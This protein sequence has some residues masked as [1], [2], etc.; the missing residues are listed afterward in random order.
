M[1]FT[2]FNCSNLQYM[3]SG[4]LYSNTEFFHKDE[5]QFEDKNKIFIDSGFEKNIYL[6]YNNPVNH[7][8]KLLSQKHIE[9]EIIS[10]FDKAILESQRTNNYYEKKYEITEKKREIINNIVKDRNRK[11]KEKEMIE[12]KILEETL[13]RII[14]DSLKFTKENSPIFAMMPNKISSAINEIKEKKKRNSSVNMNNVN[15][16]NSFNLSLISN[17]STTQCK[18]ESNGFLKALGLDLE[19]LTPDSI[20]IDIDEAYKFIKKWKINR[21]DINEIIR[22]KVVN[23]IMNVEERRSVQKLKRLN[24]K[25]DKYVEY[26]K[27]NE[28]INRQITEKSLDDYDNNI[29]LKVLNSHKL[30]QEIKQ[31]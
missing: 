2:K 21:N 19:N 7:I 30:V 13:T 24:E 4:N 12:K 27:N 26:K 1:S 14:K 29:T 18:Y 17:N 20:K 11:I 6:K 3:L 28:M 31:I 22:M 5:T 9:P 15:L 10:A 25:Y 8:D 23:E 16:G